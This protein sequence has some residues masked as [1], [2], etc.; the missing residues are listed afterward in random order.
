MRTLASVVLAS[1]L[2]D[3]QV[4]LSILKNPEYKQREELSNVIN[5]RINFL[6]YLNNALDG[7]F[8]KKINVDEI[9]EIFLKEYQQ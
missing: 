3:I 8:N 1:H 6:K 4:E 2:S 7:D 9:F 5:T